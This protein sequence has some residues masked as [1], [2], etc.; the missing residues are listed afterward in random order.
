MRSNIVRQRLTE[1]IFTA[2][3]TNF[4][5][6]CLSFDLLAGENRTYT[7]PN[8]AN[9]LA[10]G[11]SALRARQTMGLAPATASVVRTYSTNVFN[12]HE[13]IVVPGRHYLN[14][15]LPITNGSMYP[16]APNFARVCHINN[17]VGNITHNHQQLVTY[18]IGTCKS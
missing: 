3:S 15:C 8:V 1:R 18:I 13:G 2:R 5:D 6:S 9:P 12:N 10:S 14:T 16:T 11:A 17:V 7:Y 4:F